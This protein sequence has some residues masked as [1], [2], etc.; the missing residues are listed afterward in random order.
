MDFRF[1]QIFQ[2]MKLLVIKQ[3]KTGSGELFN[4]FKFRAHVTVNDL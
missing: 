2:H 3:D 4:H 1:T